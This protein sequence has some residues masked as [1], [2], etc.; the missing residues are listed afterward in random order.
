MCARPLLTFIT[1]LGLYY[2]YLTTAVNVFPRRCMHDGSNDQPCAAP[3]APHQRSSCDH[4]HW[5]SATCNGVCGLP[6]VF[7]LFLFFFFSLGAFRH[8]VDPGGLP[9]GIRLLKDP[10]DARIRRRRIVTLPPPPP[11]RSLAPAAP[12]PIPLPQGGSP[13]FSSFFWCHFCL[14]L[15]ADDAASTPTWRSS[16]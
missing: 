9:P 15:D 11:P 3:R 14:V 6:S 2:Y 4:A 8:G 16:C 13:T 10:N 1:I 12:P 7:S 5:G